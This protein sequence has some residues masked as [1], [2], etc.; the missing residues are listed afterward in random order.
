MATASRMPAVRRAMTVDA[1]TAT[2]RLNIFDNH[3]L[4]YPVVRLPMGEILDLQTGGA[5]GA[6]CQADIMANAMDWRLMASCRD[7]CRL[8]LM[9]VHI[10]RIRRMGWSPGG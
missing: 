3:T 1:G 9:A 5:I 6:A 2:V 8:V 7:V 4:S 10:K